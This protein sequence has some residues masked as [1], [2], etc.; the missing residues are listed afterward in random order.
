MTEVVVF[1]DV[2]LLVA[3]NLDVSVSLVVLT[4][5]VEVNLEVL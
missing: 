4:P 2:V 5:P 1:F 3:V